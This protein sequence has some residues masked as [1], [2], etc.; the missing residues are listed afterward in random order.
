MALNLVR[1]AQG[2]ASAEGGEKLTLVGDFSGSIGFLFNVYVGENGDDTDPPALSGKPGRPFLI[3]PRTPTEM[4]IFLPLTSPG[5]YSMH[6]NRTDDGETE[7][8]NRGVIITPKQFANSVFSLRRPF[9]PAYGVGP[10]S[11]QQIP[12]SVAT[13][14]LSPDAPVVD[15]PI[16]DQA[17]TITGTSNDDFATLNVYVDSVLKGSG[18]VIG[19]VWSVSVE[20]VLTGETVT[21]ECVTVGGTSAMS[22]GVV[23]S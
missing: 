20:A 13:P 16:A 11:I 14:D 21:A 3:G 9:P 19:G 15:G 7:T 8:I 12:A 6:I 5:I 4:D 22:A 23:V 1:F 10:R 17:T 2:G 18:T